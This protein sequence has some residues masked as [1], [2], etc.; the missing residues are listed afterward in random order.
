[1]FG[2][3]KPSGA[4]RASQQIEVFDKNTNSRITYDSIAEAA[5]A[6]NIKKGVID[7]FL[8]RNQVKPYKGR[9]IFKKL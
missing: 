5:R 2:K 9:Y 7:M 3:P 8:V 1:M 4:G 6:L